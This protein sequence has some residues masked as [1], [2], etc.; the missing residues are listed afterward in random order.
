MFEGKNLNIKI[1]RFLY[2]RYAGVWPHLL[3]GAFALAAVMANS[4][5]LAVTAATAW[6]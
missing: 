2:F 5:L 4:A 6:Q 1:T 3:T